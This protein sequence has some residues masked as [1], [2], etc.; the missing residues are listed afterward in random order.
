MV[1]WLARSKV[2]EV[3][4]RDQDQQVVGGVSI[5]LHWLRFYCPFTTCCYHH[6][7][8]VSPLLTHFI[9]FRRLSSLTKY[10]NETGAIAP[11]DFN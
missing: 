10:L 5:P 9:W 11:R 1:L 3:L 6:L 2:V 8:S 7:Y 4:C